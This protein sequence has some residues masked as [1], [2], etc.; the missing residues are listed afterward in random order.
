MT[1]TIYDFS[2]TTLSHERLDLATL[3]GKVLLIVNTASKCGFT[4]QYSELETLY[5]N[6]H[7]QGLE[8]LA[9]PCNQFGNQEPGDA[10]Q[11]QQFCS[12]SY[13]IDF[14]LMAKAEVNGENAL[15]LYK[16]LKT[17]ARGFLGSSGIKWNFTKFLISRDGA[18]IVR[19]APRVKPLKLEVGI[20]SLLAQDSV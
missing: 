17:Q 8:I 6:Y 5:K 7:H 9:F 11:I 4:N 3:K 1:P 13:G 12:L 14:P 10:L 19:Y 20:Q 16:F 15:P 18:T 2:V